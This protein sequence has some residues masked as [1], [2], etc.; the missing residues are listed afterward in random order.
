MSDENSVKS[1]DMTRVTVVGYPLTVGKQR[2]SRIIITVTFH[3]RVIRLHNTTNPISYKPDVE[4]KSTAP[5]PFTI[6]D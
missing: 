4:Q 1:N 2:A 3:C 6:S 5:L